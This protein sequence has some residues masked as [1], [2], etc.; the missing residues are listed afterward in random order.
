MK[1]RC[2]GGLALACLTLAGCA[3]GS[4]YNEPAI[5]SLRPIPMASYTLSVHDKRDTT[6]RSA[7]STPFLSFPGQKDRVSPGMDGALQQRLDRLIRA[8]QQPGNRTLNFDAELI[9]GW[10]QFSAQLMSETESVAWHI[11]L[12]VHE[13]NQ[14]IGSSAG[15][16]EGTH[17]GVDAS[18]DE[19][20]RMY[21]ACF[22][23]AVKNALNNLTLAP[24]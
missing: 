13:N 24:G 6:Q 3:S 12:A 16:C 10:Q 20:Q 9:E 19:L 22:E 2:L 15:H 17:G 18:Q 8:A 21:Y 1:H 7:P 5:T 14:P 11:K 23:R 4:L